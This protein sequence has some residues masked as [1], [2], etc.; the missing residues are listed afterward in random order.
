MTPLLLF[1]GGGIEGS[2]RA[3]YFVTRSLLRK[4]LMTELLF[5]YSLFLA[6]TLTVVFA[7][8]VILLLIRRSKLTQRRL[9]ERLEIINLNE[10]HRLMA[11]VLK[12]ATV[13]KKQFQQSI[14]ADKEKRTQEAKRIS[15]EAKV[16]RRVFVMDF[17]GDI[18]ATAVAALRET[19]TAI[20]MEA[21]P[22]DE[23]LL[24]LENAGGLV[25]E[26]GL[27]AS[28]LVR[29]RQREIPLTVAVDKVAA[30]GGYLMAC[31]ADRLIAAPFAVLG[32]IG[33]LA[34][35]PNLHR[36]MDRHGIDFEQLKAGQYKR[37][38]TL[39]GENTEEDRAKL[40]AQL[41]ET[42]SLFQEFVREY[43][44]QLDIDKVAT[45][46]YWHGKQALDLNL[47]DGLLT[48]DDY[49]MEAGE[50]AEVFLLNYSVRK[51]PLERL[52]SAAKSIYVGP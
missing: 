38:L 52:V 27:A 15:R 35:V 14:K 13:P 20:L 12:K 5:D 16:R 6:K 50:L 11:K 9:P 7:V 49:L 42:H 19:I 3:R 28:Q 33:V 36:L 26:H 17:H 24:R 23:V 43:R 4:Q 41:D 1:R 37:T 25:H 46:E 2:D 48:S 21:K 18:K 51:R 45:G 34:Q 31:V 32:S 30:S 40:Q 8:G 22:E 44:P 29:I 39:F 47:I 10:K